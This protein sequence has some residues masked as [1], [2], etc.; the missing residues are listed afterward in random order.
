ML[1]RTYRSSLALWG[2]FLCLV[3]A[4]AQEKFHYPERRHG[5]GQLRYVNGVPVLLVQGTSEEIGDQVA[6]LAV[7]PAQR[8]VT[9]PKELLAAIGAP[10]M[11]GPVLAL[12]KSMLPQFPEA[13]RREMDAMLR[14]YPQYADLLIAG[15]TAFDIKKMVACSSLIVEP[16]RSKNGRL[17]FGRNLDFPGLDFLHEYTLVTVYRPQGK[18]AFVSVGFPGMVGV[19]SGMN[20]AGL[21]LAISESFGSRDKA[22][23]FDRKGVPYALIFR[24]ILE[25]CGTLDEAEALLRS[26]PRTTHNNL[27]I[28]DVKTGGVLEISTKNVVRRRAADGYCTCTNHFL[29]PEMCLRP[30]PNTYDTLDR[31]GA[32]EKFRSTARFGLEEVSHALHAANMGELTLQS[33]IFEPETRTLYL[34]LGTPPATRQPYHAIPLKAL[35]TGQWPSVPRPGASTSRPGEGTNSPPAGKSSALKPG[36]GPFLPW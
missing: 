10:R 19:L 11:W 26:L 35:F 7:G 34:A 31:L 1:S 33:M 32:L 6:N 8:M 21:S 3:P 2:L 5:Q 13:Y 23:A 17:L 36:P 15:N 16:T 20:E 4:P 9:Y 12:G 24:R 29:S 25:E 30:T 22:P 18:R 27:T 28:C 14:R